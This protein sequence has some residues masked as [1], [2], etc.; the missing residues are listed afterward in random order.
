VLVRVDRIR[1][2]DA[3]LRAAGVSVELVEVPFADHGFDS[4]ANGFGAQ[5]EETLV[6]EFIERLVP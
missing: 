4:A 3:A 2:L 6:P 1:A 5:L